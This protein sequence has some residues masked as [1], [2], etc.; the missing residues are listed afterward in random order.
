MFIFVTKWR[1]YNIIPPPF[2]FL[3]SLSFFYLL[4]KY[5]LNCV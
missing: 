1:K 2:P 4:E 5:F 3:E